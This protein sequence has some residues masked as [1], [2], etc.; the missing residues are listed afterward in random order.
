MER[1]IVIK[2]ELEPRRQLTAARSL[3]GGPGARYVDVECWIAARVTRVHVMEARP[4]KPAAMGM[5]WM[6]ASWESAEAQS[7][8]GKAQESE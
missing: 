8:R 4:W 2:P 1:P 5:Q 6:R 3:A 7:A